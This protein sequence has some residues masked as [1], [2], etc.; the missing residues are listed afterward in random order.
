MITLASK[1]VAR[2]NMLES[3]G[4]AFDVVA[5]TSEE[6]ERKAKWRGTPAELAIALAQD[7]ALSISRVHGEDWVIGADQTLDCDGHLFTKPKNRVEAREQLLTLREKIHH[8]HAAVTLA[9]QGQTTWTHCETV[10]LTMRHFS[11]AFL[12]EYLDTEIHHIIHCVGTYRFEGLGAQ[13]FSEVNGSY[14]AILGMPLLP[15]LQKL[16]EHGLIAT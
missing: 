5:P 11:D 3:A 12:E 13:L 14:H 7:K 16:R 1:S 15:L 9:H 10:S 6:A 2:R 4:I 8:L